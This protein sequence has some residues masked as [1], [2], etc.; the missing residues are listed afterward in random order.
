MSDDIDMLLHARARATSLRSIHEMMGLQPAVPV[1]LGLAFAVIE[2]ANMGYPP[3]AGDALALAHAYGAS[4][5]PQRTYSVDG[6]GRLSLLQ[7]VSTAAELVLLAKDLN[8]HSMKSADRLAYEK[9]LRE[10]AERTAAELQVT[11]DSLQAELAAARTKHEAEI[12]DYV[13]RLR[14][15]QRSVDPARV[16][17]AVAEARRHGEQSALAELQSLRAANVRL[18]QRCNELQASKRK[19]RDA[20]ERLKERTP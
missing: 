17:D 12:N 8:S 7:P 4:C 14:T 3:L 2:S 15:L 20:L 9:Q 10:N 6:D 11:R 1:E 5:T 18:E 16:S 19:L 13:N